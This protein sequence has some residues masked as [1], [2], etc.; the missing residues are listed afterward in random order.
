MGF[1][2]SSIK[3]LEFSQGESEREDSLRNYLNNKID[4]G[5]DNVV[6]GRAFMNILNE[7]KLNKDMKTTLTYENE[8]GESFQIEIDPKEI[9]ET[10]FGE[11][12]FS[13]LQTRFEYL[14]IKLT[15]ESMIL[16]EK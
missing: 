4:N 3:K 11:S 2:K 13:E 1:E 8:R 9:L 16:K 10:N 5:K 14:G 7:Q 12:S 15:P 6:G